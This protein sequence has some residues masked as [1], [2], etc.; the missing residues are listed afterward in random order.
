[1]VI[2][3][4]CPHCEGMVEILEINCSIFRHGVYKTNNQQLN[5]HA[6]EPVCSIVSKQNLIYGCGKPFKL[7]KNGEK[8]LAIKCE[9]I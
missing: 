7:L 5:P 2:Y 4:Q 6:S 8:Y 1:M 3:V 9:Y